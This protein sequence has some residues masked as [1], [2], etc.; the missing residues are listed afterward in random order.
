MVAAAVDKPLEQRVID[1]ACGSGTFLFHAVRALLCAARA[2]GMPPAAAARRA[3]DKIAGIDIHPVAVILARV[4]YILA[5]MPALREEHP[6]DMA[7]PV[8]LGDALQWNLARTGEE[9]EHPDLLADKDTLEIFVSAD[10]SSGGASAPATLL[11]PA[12]VMSDTGKFDRL[13]TAAGRKRKGLIEYVR[14]E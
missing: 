7:L 6:G 14:H 8:Y 2:S 3:A 13:T 10:D 5:L 9:G 1:P 4:T 12:A 11:F